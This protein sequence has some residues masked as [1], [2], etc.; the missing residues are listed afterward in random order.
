LIFAFPACALSIAVPNCDRD[1]R[2]A[3]AMLDGCK[4]SLPHVVSTIPMLTRP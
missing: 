1:K 3:G 2:L 4:I